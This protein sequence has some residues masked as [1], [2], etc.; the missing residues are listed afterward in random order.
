MGVNETTTLPSELESLLER[1]AH[2][3]RD[4]YGERYEGLVL[5][6]SRARGDAD[7]DS[8]VDLLLLLRGSVDPVQEILRIEP[9]DW[10]LSLESGYVLSVLPVSAVRFQT[11][12]E[13]YLRNARKEG[14]EIG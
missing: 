10:P 11:A 2:G 3:L 9:V 4:L 14:I 1:L 7:E 12:T 13:P 6:G 8:D 5:F